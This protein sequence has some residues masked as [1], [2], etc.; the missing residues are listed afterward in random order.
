MCAGSISPVHS[1][2]SEI[3]DRRD[4]DAWSSFDIENPPCQ[5]LF[6]AVFGEIFFHYRELIGIDGFLPHL[7]QINYGFSLSIEK[8]SRR[9]N[10]WQCRDFQ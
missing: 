1:S 2:A 5:S 4:V 8:M 6:A 10:R 3:A 9:G 7:K